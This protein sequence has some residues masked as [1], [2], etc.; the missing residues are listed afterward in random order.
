LVRAF[1]ISALL[2]VLPLPLSHR[3]FYCRVPASLAKD[4]ALSPRAKLLYLVLAAHADARTGRAYLR[5]RKL[6]QHLGCGRKA[7]EQAQLEL[8]RT[9]WLRLERKVAGNGRWGSR[10]F[11]VLFSRSTATAPF[12]RSGEDEHF[13]ITHSLVPSRLPPFARVSQSNENETVSC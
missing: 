7:R 8:V 2:G 10:I 6:E 11:V 1:S 12:R 13:F 3:E 5:L 4:F 9:G